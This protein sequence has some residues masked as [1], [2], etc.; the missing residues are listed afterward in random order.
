MLFLEFSEQSIKVLAAVAEDRA[1]AKAVQH[2]ARELKFVLTIYFDI[3]KDKILL[4]LKLDEFSLAGGFFEE[5][6][7]LASEEVRKAQ[8]T[9]ERKM[10]IGTFVILTK[11]YILVMANASIDEVM[12]YP[13]ILRRLT[14]ADEGAI[15][16]LS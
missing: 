12:Q 9:A 5:E 8:E 3:L 6:Y 4:S 11:T 10:R 2:Y 15:S 14:I 16:L 7:H 1:A 13:S